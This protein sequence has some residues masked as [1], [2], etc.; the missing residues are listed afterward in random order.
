MINRHNLAKREQKRE[1][2]FSIEKRIR[3]DYI[4]LII[5]LTK[6]HCWGY[7]RNFRLKVHYNLAQVGIR[8]QCKGYKEKK[9]IRKGYEI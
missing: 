7:N 8:I 3:P 5:I 6:R 1:G 4:M 9:E 2:Y